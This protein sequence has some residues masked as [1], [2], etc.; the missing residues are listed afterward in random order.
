M[1]S[2]KYIKPYC[3]DIFELIQKKKKDCFS[4]FQF[5]TYCSYLEEN[6]PFFSS[7][8]CLQGCESAHS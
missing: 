7:L 5:Y 6:I 2:Y 4:P 1:K 8:Q 3:S